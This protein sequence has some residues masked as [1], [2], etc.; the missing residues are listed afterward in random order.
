MQTKPMKS[1]TEKDSRWISALPDDSFL[2]RLIDQLPVAA[3]GRVQHLG[4]IYLLI[5]GA[6][7]N[8][9]DFTA[10]VCDHTGDLLVNKRKSLEVAQRTYRYM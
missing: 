7:N 1:Q 6:L 4:T 5:P 2:S 3:L 8:P 10:G 9:G